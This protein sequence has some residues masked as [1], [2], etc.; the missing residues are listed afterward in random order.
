LLLDLFVR[1]TKQYFRKKRRIQVRAQ[2]YMNK[3]RILRKGKEA[4]E[5]AQWLRAHTA[6][7]E[8]LSSILSTHIGHLTAT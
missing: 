4:G 8:K 6:L 1:N 2:G 5:M 3:E 7:E